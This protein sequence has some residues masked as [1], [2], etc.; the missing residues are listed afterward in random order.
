MLPLS[1]FAAALSFWGTEIFFVN[2]GYPRNAV[3]LK[4]IQRNRYSTANSLGQ[5]LPANSP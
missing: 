2:E 3:A 5:R 1:Q 4:G